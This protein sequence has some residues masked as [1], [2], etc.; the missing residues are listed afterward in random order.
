VFL[1]RPSPSSSNV[2]RWPPV[3]L[4]VLSDFPEEL[5]DETLE[6]RVYGNR[7]REKMVDYNFYLQRQA[8][9]VSDAAYAKYAKD[10][11]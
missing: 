6:V 11:S 1:R 9:L 7:F 8:D 10:W 4:R 5:A 3:K 2:N